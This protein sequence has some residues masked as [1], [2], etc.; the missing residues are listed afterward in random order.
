MIPR[1]EELKTLLLN[2]W[3][4]IGVAGIAEA[5]DEYDSY[6][7]Q[8]HAMLV[9]GARPESVAEFLNWVATSRMA[10]PGDPGRDRKIAARSAALYTDAGDDAAQRKSLPRMATGKAS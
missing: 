10:L 4:P 2:D 7:L 9:G 3:D 5:A 6:A 1:L 8:I